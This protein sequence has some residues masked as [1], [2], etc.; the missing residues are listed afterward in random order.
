[1]LTV[2]AYPCSRDKQNMIDAIPKTADLV[3]KS[4]EHFPDQCRNEVRRKRFYVQFV[5]TNPKYKIP[6]YIYV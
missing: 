4:L 6:G 2:L 1:M 5:E 3:W